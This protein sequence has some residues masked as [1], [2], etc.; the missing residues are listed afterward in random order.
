MDKKLSAAALVAAL[1]IGVATGRATVEQPAA[2]AVADVA[3]E[4]L[5]EHASA[6]CAARLRAHSDNPQCRIGVVNKG[7]D[8]E[9]EGWICNGAWM[10]SATQM[11]LS[12]ALE[13]AAK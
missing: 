12:A 5:L 9:Q 4:Q 6:E 11:C 8:R 13:A 10:G 7:T 3:T 1:A 2:P